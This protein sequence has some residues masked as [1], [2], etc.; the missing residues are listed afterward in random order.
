MSTVIQEAS[1]LTLPYQ[2]R[3][4]TGSNIIEIRIPTAKSSYSMTRDLQSVFTYT[5]FGHL[6]RFRGVGSLAECLV[7]TEALGDGHSFRI[8]Y[9][10]LLEG[11]L[12]VNLVSRI[13]EEVA[14]PSQRS[15]SQPESDFF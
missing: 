6:S 14:H 7:E 10:I 5:A 13:F 9:E 8:T 3:R 15:K 12:H 1:C 4:D 11:S 2:E